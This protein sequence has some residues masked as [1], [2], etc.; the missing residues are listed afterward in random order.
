MKLETMKYINLR[1]IEGLSSEDQDE[2]AAGWEAHNGS[3]HYVDQ[4]DDYMSDYC[5]S[6]YP[7][8][9]EALLK[10][11]SIL[12]VAFPEEKGIYIEVDW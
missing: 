4:H 11:N 5:M 6:T 8:H 12:R 3:Y 2:L 7:K 1:D 10:L 9:C